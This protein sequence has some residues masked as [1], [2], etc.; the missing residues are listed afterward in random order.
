MTSEVG[1]IGF[2]GP[3]VAPIK[4]GKVI[5]FDQLFFRKWPIFTK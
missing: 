5:G 3:K 1:G 4:N 2:R